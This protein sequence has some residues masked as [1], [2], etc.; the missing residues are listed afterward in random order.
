M[1]K[2]DQLIE[3]N[4]D[5]GAGTEIQP[6]SNNLLRE[7]IE[8]IRES[9]R[10]ESENNNLNLSQ[11]SINKR[12]KEQIKEKIKNNELGTPFNIDLFLGMIVQEMFRFIHT[13][14]QN[15][16]D[17]QIINRV[18]ENYNIEST[19][20]HK[21]L[22]PV[23]RLY[24]EN[25]ERLSR[26][27][28]IK[29]LIKI[30]HSNTFYLSKDKNDLYRMG[31][32]LSRE[33][34]SRQGSQDAKMFFN[35][36]LKIMGGGISMKIFMQLKEDIGISQTRVIYLPGNPKLILKELGDNV[37]E[38]LKESIS[39]KEDL[40][41]RKP[42]ELLSYDELGVKDPIDSGTE[43]KL[44][45]NKFNGMNRWA[46]YSMSDEQKQ[47][48]KN[49]FFIELNGFPEA[50]ILGVTNKRVVEFITNNPTHLT[51]INGFDDLKRFMKSISEFLD[52]VGLEPEE[53]AAFENR[54]K[55]I[56]EIARNA[57]YSNDALVTAQHSFSTKRKL[58]KLI[59][60]LYKKK[61]TKEAEY[62]E[63]KYNS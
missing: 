10:K 36:L 56:L 47:V 13:I 31:K 18:K 7:Y 55:E 3:V 19:E 59:N 63:K 8:E 49:S 29:Y 28:F 25:D 60:F 33:L 46:T 39:T 61:L 23:G 38:Y 2:K 30:L 58:I 27:V 20:E 21:M 9:V 26:L 17:Q 45:I 53:A 6:E 54:K 37:L 24:L 51:K 15:M 12:V 57:I 40:I 1:R 14:K 43:L 5:M 50:N 4:K 48:A 34:L 35:I 44:F 42:V 11:F 62:L 52:E 32:K 16:S 41:V 22:T